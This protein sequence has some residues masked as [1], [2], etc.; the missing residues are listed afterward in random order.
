MPDVRSSGEKKDLQPRAMRPT[1]WCAGIAACS[2]V[3]RSVKTAARPCFEAPVAP[4]SVD[5]VAI[6][7]AFDKFLIAMAYWPRRG[8]CSTN[9]TCWSL[10]VPNGLSYRHTVEWR[11]RLR[12]ALSAACSAEH[13]LQRWPG[14]SPGFPYVYRYSL[15][16]LD[17]FGKPSWLYAYRCPPRYVDPDYGSG[18][19]EVSTMGKTIAKWYCRCASRIEQLLTEQAL[20]RLPGSTFIIARPRRRLTRRSPSARNSADRRRRAM[21]YTAS[22][23]ASLRSFIRSEG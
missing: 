5:A 15:R 22:K 21:F 10:R 23:N 1:L 14:T 4:G 12:I 3:L 11:H 16:A 19:N 2:T 9:E 6:W 17:K 13:C 7:N 20:I 8:L 18:V